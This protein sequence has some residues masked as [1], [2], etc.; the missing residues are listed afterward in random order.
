MQKHLL[1]AMAALCFAIATTAQAPTSG[2][3][4]YWPLNGNFSDQSG[5][6]INTTNTG[7]T[8][9]TNNLGTVNT[10]MAFN[11]PTS[12]P[13]QY[14]LQTNNS[15]VNFSTAQNFTIC[16]AVF[17]NSPYAHYTGIYDN[18]LN[19]S[20]YGVWAWNTN[21]FLQAQFN[22]RNGSV[23]TTNGALT[24]GTWAHLTCVRNSGTI[25]IYVNGVLNSS[26]AEGT[27]AP[28]YPYTPAF[29]GMYFNPYSPPVYNPLHGKL[30]EMRIYNRALSGAEITQTY[31]AWLAGPLPVKLT[32]FTASKNDNG[33]QLNWQTEYVQNSSYFNVQRSTDGANFTTIG[34]VQANGNTVVKSNYQYTDFTAANSMSANK[35]IYY[36][37]QQVDKDNRSQY[38]NIV[39]VKSAAADK[40]LAI[41]QNPVQN[42][43]RLEVLLK[44]RQE[45]QFII[46]DAQGRAATAKQITMNAGQTFT[47]LPTDR[48]A[49]G[50]YYITIIAGTEKQTLSFVKQ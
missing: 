17:F 42:E 23:G 20:G 2:L 7:A 19:Y 3:V 5:T 35:T 4:A 32:S 14:A 45:I 28:N 29:G 34:T 1:T 25:S 37:L 40:L 48:L 16:C 49:K 21:G 50:T 47:A 13:A 44:Q 43:I 39:F 11:N 33:V 24:A 31:N 9:T 8:A 26:G 41:M 36:R 6:G 18:N 12:T 15:A 38:S 27:T 30:D 10:A 22:F 46:T